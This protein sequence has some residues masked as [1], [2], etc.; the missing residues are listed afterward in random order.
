MKIKV[1]A[2]ILICIFAGIGF[3]LLNSC[4]KKTPP[5]V[6][7]TVKDKTGA[8]VS[9]AIVE[10]FSD[11]TRYHGNT[12]GLGN[13]GYVNADENKIKLTATSDDGG[14][15]LFTGFKNE[16]ILNVKGTKGLAKNDTIRGEGAVILKMNSTAQETITLR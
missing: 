8:P 13:V 4:T 6:L 2:Y 10:I 1:L 11:P 5:K 9:G 15:A 7:I 12:T 16:C 3:S 14:Q